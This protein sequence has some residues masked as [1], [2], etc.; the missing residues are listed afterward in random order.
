VPY[1]RRVGEVPPKRHSQF[2]SPDGDLYTE[3]LV[4]QQGFFHASS[5]VYHR[6][7]P[8]VLL[9]AETVDIPALTAPAIPAQPLLPR[10]MQTHRLPIGGDAVTGRR[11]LLGN[12]DLRI[13]YVVATEASP[14]FRN[15]CG[16]ELIFVETGSGVLESMFGVLAV[17]D[18]DYV[19][20]PMGTVHRWDPDG[21]ELR[22]LV[23]ESASHVRIPD[24]YVSPRGQ[25]LETAPYHERDL[26]GP[27]E[28]LSVDDGETEVLIRHR[29]GVTK[30][31]FAHHPFDLVGWDGTVFPYALS[32]RD[33]EPIVKRFHAPPPVHETFSAPGFSVCSFCPRPVDFDPE[34]IPAPYAHAAVDCD[35]MMF[36]VSGA[37]TTRPDVGPGTMTFHPAGFVHGPSPGAAEASIRSPRHEEY[38]VMVDTFRPLGLGADAISCADEEYYRAWAG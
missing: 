26:R 4:G 25:L 8:N 21:G 19:V 30:H 18:G 15:A 10:R 5:L 37:Y 23:L 33:F 9:A 24:R 7:T 36:F 32:I 6:N 22:L 14:L 29:G 38:A 28:L 12:D 35:E 20:V 3:E 13:S 11:L 34:A 31:T 27:T 1:Y 16:D 2:R 17:R